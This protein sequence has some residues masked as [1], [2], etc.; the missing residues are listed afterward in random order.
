M[1]EN[2]PKVKE[3]YAISITEGKATIYA[4]DDAGILLRVSC[5]FVANGASPSNL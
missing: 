2:L 1:W 3:A 4:N 5:I